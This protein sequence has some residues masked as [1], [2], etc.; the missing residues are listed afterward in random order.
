[1]DRGGWP[2]LRVL[3]HFAPAIPGIT[4]FPCLKKTSAEMILLI[5]SKAFLRESDAADIPELP[6]P[7]SALPLGSKNYVTA[8]GAEQLSQELNR[9]LAGRQPLLAESTVDPESK[10]ALQSLDRRIRHLRESL[11]TAVLVPPPPAEERDMVKFGAAVDVIEASGERSRYHLVG[12]D[13][14]DPER[15]RISWTSPMARALLNAR[16][17]DRITFSTP[18]GQA[19][20]EIVDIS[21]DMKPD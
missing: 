20:L 3:H 21:Y 5:M 8:A 16:R 9:L 13:E 2:K 12:V 10:R 7:A 15:G 14:A 11:R 1:M 17:G 6:P 18:S 19:E 4:T